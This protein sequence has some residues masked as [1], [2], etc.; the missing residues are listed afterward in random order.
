MR[1]VPPLVLLTLLLAGLIGYRLHQQSQAMTGPS[2]GSGEVEATTVDLSSRVGARVATRYVKEGDRVKKGDLVLRLECSD[3]GAQVAEAKAR[4]EAARAQAEAAGAQVSAS[5]RTQW[6]A[7]AAGEAAKAQTSALQ[8]QREAA[9]R[10]AQRLESI[11]EDVPASNVDAVRSNAIGLGHQV[12][13]ARAQATASVAQATAAAV[14]VKASGAQASAAL[15][16][17]EA[18]EAAVARAELYAAEC[19]I[20]APLDAEVSD[21]PYEPGELVPPG[22]VLARLVSLAEL[23][24]TFYLPNAEVGKVKPGAPA[25][26]V[27]DAWP[28]KSFKAKVRTV[29]LEAEFTPRN[30]Q[31]RSDRDRLVY[32]V[33]VL[34]E[35]PGQHLRAGMPVEV[36][37]P[38]TEQKR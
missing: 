12:E 30:I 18:A 37:L 21:L 4:L 13:A 10:Q 6:A 33:E 31:T 2:G 5:K 8:A 29:A 1:I 27:A 16:Q 19:E 9:E 14:A 15:A 24:A 34:I 23:T 32:P 11:P 20:R 7:I 35:N 17:V 26:V 3:P 36:T 28:G 22:A 25:L 38:G